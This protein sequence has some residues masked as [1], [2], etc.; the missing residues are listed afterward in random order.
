MKR[1]GGLILGVLLG[2]SVVT[3]ADS[4]SELISLGMPAQ[5][6]SY[7][8]DK[9]IGTDS[10]GNI[11]LPAATGKAVELNVAGVTVAKADA[12]GVVLPVSGDTISIQEAT[13]ASK[14]MGT[15]TANGITAVTTSTT[16]AVTG[17]RIFFSGTSDPTGSTAAQC[18][19]TNIVTGVS[20]DFDCDQANDGTYNWF[21][22][23]EAP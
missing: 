8:K 15:L 6:A 2:F 20:F 23:K 10:S 17:A 9:M 14:C 16:C 13:A 3:L 18:W 21:I 19:T 12:T 7:M 22:F 5:L 11:E 4:L 1:F